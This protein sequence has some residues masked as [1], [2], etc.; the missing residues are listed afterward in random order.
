MT[1]DAQ[2]V[3]REL[4]KLQVVARKLVRAVEDLEGLEMPYP[5]AKRLAVTADAVRVLL[6]EPSV[7]EH[8]WRK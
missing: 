2:N 7:I 5:K 8:S 3:V 1:S 6:G 4:A